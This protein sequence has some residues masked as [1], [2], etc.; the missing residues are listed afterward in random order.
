MIFVG[1]I[2]R[3]LTIYTKQL[4]LYPIIETVFL[5]LTKYGKKSKKKKIWYHFKVTRH[6]SSE[7]FYVIVSNMMLL[8]WN[9]NCMCR[10]KFLMIHDVL[11]SLIRNAYLKGVINFCHMENYCIL[12]FVSCIFVV[13]LSNHYIK[14]LYSWHANVISI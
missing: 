11:Q 12:V 4:I 7:P 14:W 8:L 5:Q 9:K 13:K 10:R 6:V 1:L 3:T 2:I